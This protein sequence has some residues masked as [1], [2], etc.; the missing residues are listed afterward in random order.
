M[1]HQ[2]QIVDNAAVVVAPPQARP[3]FRFH[4]QKRCGLLAAAAVA[5]HVLAL[6]S[7]SLVAN[8][9]RH[10]HN[11]L[12]IGTFA[13]H[14]FLMSLAFA[15]CST[16]AVLAY[17][18][19]E[20]LFGLSHAMA[21]LFHFLWNT[22]AIVVATLGVVGM[23]SV[24]SRSPDGHFQSLH[25]WIGFIVFCMYWAQ[26]LLGTVVYMCNVPVD[27]KRIVL[28]T[29]V[30][31]GLASTFGVYLV[32]LLGIIYNNPGVH[33]DK[34]AYNALNW[35][36]ITLF[37]AVREM[38]SCVNA[39]SEILNLGFRSLTLRSAMFVRFVCC[40]GTTV[41]FLQALCV[42][43]VIAGSRKPRPATVRAAGLP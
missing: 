39:P 9:M 25:S 30:F 3:Q 31:L 36:G 27:W 8:V 10:T 20:R 33:G 16:F 35:A 15:V 18:T 24:H 22:V 32:I 37:F 2:Y 40:T 38:S 29:H 11:S 41:C 19:Y 13:N 42:G 23:Y 21:K 7:F 6:A 12:A 28:P 4:P 34:Y 43:Y 1:S 26:Y 17:F 5:A 14:P